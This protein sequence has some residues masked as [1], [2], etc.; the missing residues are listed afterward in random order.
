MERVEVG[1]GCLQRV[2]ELRMTALNQLREVVVG[3]NCFTG[4]TMFE[5]RKCK[6]VERVVIGDNC[7]VH[8]VS[9]VFE[10]AT[11]LRGVRSRFECAGGSIVGT[12]S[13]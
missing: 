10:S 5:M 1:K 9:V 8:C 7:L 4:T 13:A 6:Q 3:S 2:E 12:G 11:C